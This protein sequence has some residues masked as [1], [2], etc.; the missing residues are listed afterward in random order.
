MRI[1]YSLSPIFEDAA[2]AMESDGMSAAPGKLSYSPLEYV[3]IGR[4]VDRIRYICAA[5]ANKVVLDLGALDE[6]AFAAKQARG[7]WLH[8][9]IAK[10][11]VRVV[12]VD[13]S[14]ALPEDGLTTA[15]NSQIRKGNIL[16]LDSLLSQID[17]SPDI[18][19]AGELIEHL[20]NPLE[21]LKMFRRVRRLAGKSLLLS[22]PNATA[23]HNCLIALAKR[24]STHHDHLFVLSFKTLSTLLARAGY[25]SWRITPYHADFAEMKHRNN[26]LSK[27]LVVA[28]ETAIKLLETIFP[29]LSFGLIA[30]TTI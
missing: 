16:D 17:V 10:S 7:A 9:E 18:V 20:E 28:G 15:K 25:E 14:D 27:R 3:P 22:T 21:F 4:P 12:G 2:R 6:T 24:E 23:L 1:L 5:C 26:G 8:E 19:V 11:A 29:L 13:W 30:E